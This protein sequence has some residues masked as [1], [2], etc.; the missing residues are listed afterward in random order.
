MPV[1]LGQSF[2]YPFKASMGDLRHRLSLSI[3][4]SKDDGIQ[5]L[6]DHV[7]GFAVR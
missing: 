3:V 6:F 1:H 4:C 5:A 7:Q 2:E